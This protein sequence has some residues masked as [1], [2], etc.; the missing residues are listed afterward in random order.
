M[1]A[2]RVG[3][4]VGEVGDEVVALALGER[5]AEQLGADHVAVVGDE[6]PV[7]LVV[8]QPLRDAGHGERV[9]DSEQDGEHQQDAD[10]GA[11]WRR[12]SGSHRGDDDVDELDPDERGDEAPDPYRRMLRRSTSAAFVARNLTPRSA[13]GINATMISALK[14]TADRIAER[15]DCSPMTLRSFRT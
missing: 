11:S 2:A 5:L 14:I 15:G 3:L 10:R 7:G 1:P 9:G 12:I 13:S 4:E 8:E 6:G